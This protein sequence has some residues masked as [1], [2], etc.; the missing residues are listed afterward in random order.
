MSSVLVIDDDEQA[1]NA[2]KAALDSAGFTS[3]L[4][5][6]GDDGL[7]KFEKE[8]F[9][10]VI[11]DVLMPGKSG[12]QTIAAIRAGAPDLPIIAI[13]DSASPGSDEALTMAKTMGAS[14][15]L[16]KPFSRDELLSAIRDCVVRNVTDLLT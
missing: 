2:A 6:S 4:A 14:C 11:C 7:E 8:K 15:T 12:M 3:T 13:A 5:A 10:L 1:R 16:S 9:D